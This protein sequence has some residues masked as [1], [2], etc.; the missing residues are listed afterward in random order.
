M[1]ASSGIFVE[2]VTYFEYGKI[3]ERYQIGKH[4]LDPIKSKA[5]LIMETLYSKYKLLFIFDNV[6]SYT[7][8]EKNILQVVHINKGLGD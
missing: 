4:L 8:Y 5:L 6:I 3:E 7:I 1:L 2:T